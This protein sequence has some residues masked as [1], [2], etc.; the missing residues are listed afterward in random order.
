[1]SVKNICK[2]CWCEEDIS[3]KD[4]IALNKKLIAKDITQFYCLNCLSEEFGCSIQDL[5]EKIKDFK[6]EGCTLFL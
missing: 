4:I 5:E 2:C 1:M 3:R 6:S